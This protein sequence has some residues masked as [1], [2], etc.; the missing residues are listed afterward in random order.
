MPSQ[1]YKKVLLLLEHES[2]D[3]KAVSHVTHAMA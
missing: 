2:R 3:K 1:M